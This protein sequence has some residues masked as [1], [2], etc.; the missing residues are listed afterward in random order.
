MRAVPAR[1]ERST[2]LQSIALVPDPDVSTHPNESVLAESVQSMLSPQCME[3]LITPVAEEVSCLSPAEASSNPS[4]AALSTLQE[5]P[6]SSPVGQNTEEAA[7]TVVPNSLA[8]ASAALTGLIPQVSAS[9]PVPG[10]LFQSVSLPVNALL[11]EKIRAKIWK[12]EYED[13]GSL[14]ANP[15]L[16]DQYQITVN[17]SESS[18]NPSLCLE[19]L[20]KN[21]KVMTIET[22]LS[23]FRVFVG[24]YTKEL[25]YK[26]PALMKYEEI[27]QDFAGRGHNWTFYDENFRF[28]RQAHRAALAWDRTH[29]ELWLTSQVSLRR[30]LQNPAHP[31]KGKADFVL[32]GYCFKFHKDPKCEG[33]HTVSKCTFLGI[34]NYQFSAPT[35]QVLTLSDSP[36]Q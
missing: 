21:K 3:T 11:S 6:V 35:C 1:T 23:S 32:K 4:P 20:S 30:P 28:L 16:A 7:S 24:A 14:H 15:V 2:Q 26:V 25:P 17:N 9:N 12:V 13:F 22:A 10:Q 36:L 19:P 18:L 33:S 27:I 5:V 29:G 34:K 31:P 8:N